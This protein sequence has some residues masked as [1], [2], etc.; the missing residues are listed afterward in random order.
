MLANCDDIVT[1][2]IYR[3]IALRKRLFF[4]KNADINKLK[5]ALVLKVIFF[6]TYMFVVPY[7]ISS[8]YNNS[9]EF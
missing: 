4:A 5:R 1:F 6:E 8:F 7:Q 2:L 9:N 3:Y